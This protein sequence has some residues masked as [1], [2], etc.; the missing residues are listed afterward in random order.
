MNS[1]TCGRKKGGLGAHV[2]MRG[3][4]GLCKGGGEACGEE[5]KGKVRSQS[6][7]YR[8]E[9]AVTWS[10]SWVGTIEREKI[11]EGKDPCRG[12]GN[13]QVIGK[14]ARVGVRSLSATID[15][16]GAGS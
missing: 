2:G 8:T 14:R 15:R 3:C 11:Q 4:A 5:G 1:A 13:V 6:C 12:G 9:A 16:K 10:S 7:V